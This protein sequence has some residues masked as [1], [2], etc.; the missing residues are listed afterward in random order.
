MRKPGLAL[1]LAH[2]VL[3]WSDPV[4]GASQLGQL[5]TLPPGLVGSRL[6]SKTWLSVQSESLGEVVGRKPSRLAAWIWRR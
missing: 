5:D 6:K 4:L 2:V 3:A 1:L